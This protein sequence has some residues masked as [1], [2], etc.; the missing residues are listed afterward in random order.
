MREKGHELIGIRLDSGDLAALS[1]RARQ[2]LDDAGLP[3][4]GDRRQQRPGRVRNR[5]VAAARGADRRLGRGD[6]IGYGLRPTGAGWRLQVVGDSTADGAWDRKLK[7]S[8]H[9]SK[10]STPGIPATRR[11]RD[12][13]WWVG[14]VIFDA[15]IGLE[16]PVVAIDSAGNTLRFPA[17]AEPEEL[18]VPVM[19]GG[20]LVYRF[21]TIHE[22]RQR[23]IDAVAEFRGSWL[24]RHDKG[25]YPVGVEQRL[26]DIKR[27][28]MESASNREGHRTQADTRSTRGVIDQGSF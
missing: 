14:D 6:T 5:V 23:A 25:P 21:P 2:M 24:H 22:T 12:G 27:R 13:G 9:P 17:S 3:A 11:Y 18:L 4:G 26:F 15:A 10:V 20:E 1:Q 28:L 19:R 16:E 8:E 7:L